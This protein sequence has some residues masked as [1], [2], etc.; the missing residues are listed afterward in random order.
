M[1]ESSLS[2]TRTLLLRYIGRFLGISRDSGDWSSTQDDDVND[3]ISSGLR[4]FYNPMVLPGERTGHVWSFLSPVLE[5]PIVA[6]VSDYDLPD[7]FS[8]FIGNQLTFAS[9]D[10]EWC[11]VRLT[12]IGRLLERRQSEAYTGD[13]GPMWAA[14]NVLP[15][16]GA[17]IGHRS[18]LMLSPAPSTIGT[19][20]GQYYSNPYNISASAIYP[21]GGQPHSETLLESCLASAELLMNDTAGLHTAK[22]MEC[23]KSSIA[24]DRSHSGPKFFGY[25]GDGS[26]GGNIGGRGDRVYRVGPEVSIS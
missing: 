17:A 8:Y 19:L 16:T 13:L 24:L 3:V 1:A 26:T 10:T 14:V 2:I 5:I 22:F 23:L 25:N 21:M 18:S 15:N 9:T 11:P 12:G 20:N 7:D 4:G 6:N